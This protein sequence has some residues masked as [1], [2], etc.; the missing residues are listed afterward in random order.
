MLPSC[1]NHRALPHLL[2]MLSVARGARR[3]ALPAGLRRAWLC[4]HT[5]YIPKEGAKAASA[6]EA[7]EAGPT[8]WD[9]VPEFVFN[10]L[11]WAGGVVGSIVAYFYRGSRRTTTEK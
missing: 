11:L 9:H 10:P 1:S 4:T 8:V 2:P 5:H 3:R 7:A 6:K